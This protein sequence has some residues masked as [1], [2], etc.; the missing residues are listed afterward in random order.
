MTLTEKP[1]NIVCIELIPLGLSRTYRRERRRRISSRVLLDRLIGAIRNM[2]WTHRMP[3]FIVCGNGER[4][5]IERNGARRG[6]LR[7]RDTQKCGCVDICRRCSS[8]HA[9]ARGLPTL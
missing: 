1:S 7:P 3:T 5:A 8:T 4:T 6:Q 9:A 2:N